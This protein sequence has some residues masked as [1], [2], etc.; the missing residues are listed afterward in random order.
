MRLIFPLSQS[1]EMEPSI[2]KNPSIDIWGL[3]VGEPVTMLT[4][5]LV[6]AVCLFAWLR[7]NR[8]E[9]KGVVYVYYKYFFLLMGIATLLGGVIGHGF[10]YALNIYWKIP[11]WYVSMVSIALAERASIFYSM[12]L[13]R[14]KY[15]TFFTWVNLA[16]LLFFMVTSVVTMN[17]YFVVGHSAYGIMLVVGGFQGYIYYR[18]RQKG[19]KQFFYAV[20]WSAIGAII[21]LN[22]WAVSRWFNHM[23][24]GHVLMALSAWHIYKGVLLIIADPDYKLK[25]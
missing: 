13:I 2:Y 1:V 9:L 18:T 14:P 16:E 15:A 23:D 19:S 8:L 7:L 10:N 11:G 17:F 6:T 22:Q 25:G 5:L 21:F 24:I 20:L 4:D 3:R 12:K